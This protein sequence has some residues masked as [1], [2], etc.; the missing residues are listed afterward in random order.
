M[1]LFAEWRDG[2]PFSIHDDNGKQVGRINSW[3]L[4]RHFN[5]NI[6]VRRRLSFLGHQWSLRPGVDNVTNRPNYNLVNNNIDSPQFH[7]LFGRSPRKLVV[8]L[9]WLGK[10]EN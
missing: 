10:A 8:R 7:N 3:R 6:H 5:L 4:P 1:A 9:R 2:F